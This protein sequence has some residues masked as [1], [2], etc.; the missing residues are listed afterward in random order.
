MLSKHFESANGLSDTSQK[1]VCWKICKESKIFSGS[2]FLKMLSELSSL[3][4]AVFFEQNCIVKWVIFVASFC[5]LWD[6]TRKSEINRQTNFS[7][8]FRFSGRVSKPIPNKRFW[9]IYFLAQILF[10]GTVLEPFNQCN[11]K[12]FHC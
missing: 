5:W 7:I 6:S 2:I 12:I 8:N 11:F 10:F 3:K 4:W 1:H 9:I